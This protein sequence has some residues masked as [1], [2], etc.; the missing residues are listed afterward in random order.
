MR[1]VMVAILRRPEVF[2][3]EPGSAPVVRVHVVPRLDGERPAAEDDRH[4][5]PVGERG[6]RIVAVQRHQHHPTGLMGPQQ[7]LE[8]GLAAG[9]GGQG[10]H[11]LEVGLL[12]YGVDADHHLGEEGVGEHRRVVARD[13]QYHGPRLPGGQ[14]AS[15]C[16]GHVSEVVD[17]PAYGLSFGAADVR[18][19]VDHPGG[20]RP[21][22]AGPFGDLVERRLPPGRI[23]RHLVPLLVC[24]T[25]PEAYLCHART[26]PSMMPLINWRPN[27]MNTSNSGTVAINVP[28][29]IN[30]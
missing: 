25:S 30:V 29:N 22:H 27:R 15:R 20:G 19:V 23:G 9:G 14:R 10:E 1:P 26:A 7:L 3:G 5:R 21:R 28:E 17:R 12:Q 2:G 24:A 13:R 4:R 18:G 8:P 16:I 6:Q 11:Q